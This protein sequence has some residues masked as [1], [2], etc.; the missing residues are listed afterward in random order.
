MI[1]ECAELVA[2]GRLGAQDCIRYSFPV[3]PLSLSETFCVQ[4]AALATT[5]RL[6][7][8]VPVAL[9]ANVN[10]MTQLSVSRA[11][12]GMR[13]REIQLNRHQGRNIGHVHNYFDNSPR[14]GAVIVI[15]TGLLES[16]HGSLPVQLH[17]HPTFPFPW[18]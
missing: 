7:E 17:H 12:S 1:H 14:S 15:A 3:A 5:V 6:A 4:N 13:A 10:E 8:R 11:N 18:R 16:G 9:S 2:E